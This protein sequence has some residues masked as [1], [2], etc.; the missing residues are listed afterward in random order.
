[1]QFKVF[2]SDWTTFEGDPADAPGWGVVVI[3]QY[4]GP[5][6][7]HDHAGLLDCLALPG[8][9]IVIHGRSVSS[10]RWRE[11]LAVADRDP[12][13]PPREDR[14]LMHGWDFY[15]YHGGEA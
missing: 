3:P 7:G 6:W 10:E 8:A 15:C 9:N 5:W 14:T 2:Y 4:G 11:F 12:D 1:M 13:F